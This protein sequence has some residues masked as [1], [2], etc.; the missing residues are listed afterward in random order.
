MTVV[1]REMLAVREEP[2]RLAVTITDWS[3]TKMPVLAVKVAEV[4]LA[5]MLTD[6]G[7]VK[8]GATLLA[9]V[10]EVVLLT[11]FDSV[12][13]QVVLALEASVAAAH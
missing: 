4:A 7:T 11:D 1:I 13:V 2:F 8:A 5:A 10:T 3:D 9:T 6:G 12:T